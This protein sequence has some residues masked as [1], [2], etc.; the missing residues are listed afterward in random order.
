MDVMLSCFDYSINMAK[1]WAAA[2]YKCY[3]IDL[4]HPKGETTNGNII[5]VGADI[6]EWLPPTNCNIVFAA[7]FPPCTDLAASGASH[8]KRKGLGA[9]INALKLFDRSIKMAEWA[10]SP[11]IIEN[12]ISTVSTYW[13]KPDYI[14]DPYQYGDDYAKRTCLWTGGGFIMPE[15]TPVTTYDKDR[16]SNVSHCKNRANIRAATPMGFANAVY[17]AN[18]P[19][20]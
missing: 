13:R 17:E 16:I 15:K 19:K 3:C 7:F 9:L 14:F 18:R 4:Q 20:V 10:G 1:P 5:K 8:F 2:G 6:M 12:P 11:Y